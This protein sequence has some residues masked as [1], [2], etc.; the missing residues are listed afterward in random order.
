MV[1]EHTL[2]KI[3]HSGKIISPRP[4][5]ISA[6]YSEFSVYMFPDLIIFQLSRT[7]FSVYMF[8]TLSDFGYPV[9]S[10]LFTCS[11]PYQNLP[12]PF[13]VFCLRVPNLIIF[14]LSRSQFS[15]YVFPD[16]I[17]F[18]LSRSEFSVY[19]FPDLIRFWL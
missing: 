18:W 2:E 13:R 14:L 5:Q 11:Q 6:S 7:E 9:Q 12:I 17:R 15:V 10:F 4:Y 1:D 8:P 3:S 19:V 16:L